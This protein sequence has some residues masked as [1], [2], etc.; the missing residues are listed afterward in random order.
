MKLSV[1]E[2][3][4]TTLQNNH[5]YALLL[6]TKA[7]YQNQMSK[8]SHFTE[9]GTGKYLQIKVCLDGSLFLVYF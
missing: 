7:H 3:P 4:L 2:I 6:N 5:T 1:A 9:A 8:L